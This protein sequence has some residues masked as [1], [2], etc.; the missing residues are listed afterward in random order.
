CRPALQVAWCAGR[1]R[2]CCWLPPS[3]CSTCP[4]RTPASSWPWSSSSLPCSGCWFVA[5]T[6]SPPSHPG[7]RGSSREASSRSDALGA[8]R[9]L[10]HANQ[11]GRHE[12][13][14]ENARALRI[15]T[16]GGEVLRSVG[17]HAQ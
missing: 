9:F 5:A 8:K 13:L 10:D 17:G 16:V 7:D 2:L 14:S 12:R 3:S 6:A 1:W 15:D 11:L 4:T